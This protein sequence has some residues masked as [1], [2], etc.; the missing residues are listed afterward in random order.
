MKKSE[1]ISFITNN[2]KGGAIVT[3]V[4][5]SKITKRIMINRDLRFIFVYSSEF[6]TMSIICLETSQLKAIG[7]FSSNYNPDTVDEFLKAS[8][9]E[10]I[11]DYSDIILRFYP[12]LNNIKSFFKMPKKAWDAFNE[13]KTRNE[14][15]KHLSEA[16]EKPRYSQKED[17][18]YFPNDLMGTLNACI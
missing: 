5:K 6:D 12:N 17:G 2:I 1:Y 18:F 10:M 14:L 4:I 15:F 13:I 16:K 7:K 8:I 3:L 9:N 11:N